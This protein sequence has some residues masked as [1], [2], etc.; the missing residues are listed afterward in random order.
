ML[1]KF[2]SGYPKHVSP[3]DLDSFKLDKFL[4]RC[5]AKPKRYP[6]VVVDD[7]ESI[8]D[9]VRK[10]IEKNPHFTTRFFID[11]TG[12][13]NQ[14]KRWV[15]IFDGVQP[16]YGIRSLLSPPMCSSRQVQSR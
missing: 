12:I 14:Y 7:N 6:V 5:L 8:N 1:K 4:D 10:Y 13:Y 9:T 15:T 3:R 16:F 2:S 11:C